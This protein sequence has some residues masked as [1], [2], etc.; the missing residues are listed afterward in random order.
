MELSISQKPST[1]DDLDL[2]WMGASKF[3][4]KRRDRSATT[5][6]GLVC[7]IPIEGPPLSLLSGVTSTTSSSASRLVLVAGRRNARAQPVF[8]PSRR[9]G[10]FPLSSRESGAQ[11]PPWPRSTCA[12]PPPGF[13][14]L[15]RPI[16]GPACRSRISLCP[17]PRSRAAPLLRS[18]RGVRLT[19]FPFVLVNPGPV[20]RQIQPD[21]PACCFHRLGPRPMRPGENPSSLLFFLN[22][23][24]LLSFGPATFF[25]C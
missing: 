7:P 5:S 3:N 15:R 11:A 8:E 25:P 14:P 21:P 4:N 1:T 24:P 9:A 18:S 23:G 22:V 13:M 17:Q 20:D 2:P 12:S 6:S 10:A 19:P 16:S